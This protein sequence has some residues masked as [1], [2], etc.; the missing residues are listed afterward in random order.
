M[1][2]FGAGPLGNSTTPHL[3]DCLCVALSRRSS[4]LPVFDPCL[5]VRVRRI[6]QPAERC[7]VCC[8]SRSQLHMAHEPAAALQQAGRIRQRCPV[9]E[10]HVYVRSE[11]IHIGERRVSQTRNRM[12]VMQNLPDFVPAFPHRLKPLMRD[13]PQFT[14]MFFHPRI[15]GQVPLDSSVES[16]QF[17]AH[18]RSSFCFRD[19][20]PLSTLIIPPADP[21]MAGGWPGCERREWVDIAI[22]QKIPLGYVSGKYRE[23]LGATG[24]LVQNLGLGAAGT[25]R[26]LPI[27]VGW[28]RIYGHG[29]LHFITFRC[30]RRLPLLKSGRPRNVF[31]GSCSWSAGGRDFAWSATW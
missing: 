7:N 29:H 2:N 10:P 1:V 8:R 17:R 16:Q 11:Y 25:F 14:C 6:D 21:V 4:G 24:S 26:G 12:A 3:T 20:W 18:P 15:D 5:Y 31:V 23:A 9:K 30:Y 28:Q 27:Q 13:R 19:V 22:K